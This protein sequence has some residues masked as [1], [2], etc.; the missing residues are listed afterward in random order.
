MEV[1]YAGTLVV[2]DGFGSCDSSGS[3]WNS[4]MASLH[5]GHSSSI[6]FSPGK[7]LYVIKDMVFFPTSFSATYFL[8]SVVYVNFE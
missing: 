1:K 5:Y 2:N 7:G 3:L 6:S 8:L 4:Y